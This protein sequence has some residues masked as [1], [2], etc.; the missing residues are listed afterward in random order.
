VNSLSRGSATSEN[1]F[2]GKGQLIANPQVRRVDN[3]CRHSTST[4]WGSW[5]F[6]HCRSAYRR[7]PYHCCSD[8]DQL[9]D[10]HECLPS[11]GGPPF[12]GCPNTC[13]RLTVGR[14][15]QAG[16]GV[17]ARTGGRSAVNLQR[18]E[19]GGRFTRPAGTGSLGPQ[20]FQRVDTIDRRS[21]SRKALALAGFARENHSAAEGRSDS[22]PQG[23]RG[24]LPATGRR[25]WHPNRTNC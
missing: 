15:P 12:F 10:A 17:P 25:I 1:G 4:S 8:P 19:A 2:V 6:R 18:S 3:S 5:V 11:C 13:V 24:E 23:R 16:A 22:R 20:P 14:G 7:I 21:G 9:A